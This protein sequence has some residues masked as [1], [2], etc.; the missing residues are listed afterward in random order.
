MSDHEDDRLLQESPPKS[1]ISTGASKPNSDAASTDLADAVSL[2][3]SVLDTQFASLSKQ[4]FTEQKTNAKSLSKKLKENTASKLRGEGNKIQFGFNEEIIEELE[5]LETLLRENSQAHLIVR[6]LKQ[7]LTKRNKLIRIADSSPAGWKTVNEYELNDYADDSDDDKRIRSAETRA[8]RSKNRGRGGRPHP[9]NRQI[10]AAAG[11]ASQLQAPT[12]IA[13]NPGYQPFRHVGG[14]RRTPQPTDLCYRC[15]NYG[16]WK[17]RCPLNMAT[18][19]TSAT[20]AA[21]QK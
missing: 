20:G 9:Y 15:F 16:H 2:F 19:Q 21:S 18:H 6:D 12:S 10:P 8:L 3:K 7:K 17:N 11:S 4:L 1:Q 5:N 14:S 13:V